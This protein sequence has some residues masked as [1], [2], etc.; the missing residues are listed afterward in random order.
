MTGRELV[1]L[2]YNSP[3]R[4]DRANIMARYIVKNQDEIVRKLENA[5]FSQVSIDRLRQAVDYPTDPHNFRHMW[6]MLRNI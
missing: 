1:K 3:S 6:S 2:A 4:K 5:G